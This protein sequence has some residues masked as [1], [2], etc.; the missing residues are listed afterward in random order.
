VYIKYKTKQK[1]TNKQTIT[2][3]YALS[4]KARQEYGKGRLG[5]VGHL[6][7]FVM[8]PINSEL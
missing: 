5:Q 8:N 6:T 3:H 4:P 7:K 1:Q 2:K